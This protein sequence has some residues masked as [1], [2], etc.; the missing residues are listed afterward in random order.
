MNLNKLA[1]WKLK[2]HINKL[3]KKGPII[4]VRNYQWY[5]LYTIILF[6]KNIFC[7]SWHSVLTLSTQWIHISFQN[8]WDFHFKWL[9]YKCKVKSV[10]N[11]SEGKRIYYWKVVLDIS[12]PRWWNRSPLLAEKSLSSYNNTSNLLFL[13]WRWTRCKIHIIGFKWLKTFCSFWENNNLNKIT[14]LLK[15]VAKD[16]TKH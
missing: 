7:S 6:L 1:T 3:S 9:G 14:P 10:W 12:Y 11:Q 4:S 16:W 2:I 8:K 15:T 5:I 13:F